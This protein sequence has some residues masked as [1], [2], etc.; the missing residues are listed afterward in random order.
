MVLH[1]VEL[2]PVDVVERAR[3]GDVAA[4]EIVI[5]AFTTPLVRFLTS[6][7]GGD[8]HAAN[9]VAQEAFVAA[10]RSLP[11]LHD[12][13]HLRAWLFRTAWHQALSWMRRR[14]PGG[15]PVHCFGS[16][17]DPDGPPVDL[18]SPEPAVRRWPLEDGWVTTEEARPHLHALLSGLPPH[19]AAPITLHYLQGL[20]T[21][22]TA[23]ALN[24]TKT[25]VKMR[26]HRARCL[27]RR[28][29]L[30]DDGP[31]GSANGNGAL[32][33]RNGRAP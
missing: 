13:G 1:P 29:L 14:T 30:G 20:T 33:G 18:P 8:F 15:I 25:T 17:G 32:H 16:F 10:W 9:D 28:R 22:E 31:A 23:R 2:I 11:S 19:Y 5:A 4:F 6:R 12:P 24:L 7:L 21:G 26:L 3:R 27:M